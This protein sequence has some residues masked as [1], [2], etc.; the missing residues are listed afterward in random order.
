M[1]DMT[2]S[3]GGAGEVRKHT[4]WFIALGIVFII[5]GV[6]AI[7]MPLLA[8]IAVALAVG[9]ALILLGIVQLVQAWSMRSWGGVVWQIIIGLVFVIGGIGML[10]NPIVAAVT[11]TLLIGL[12]FIIKGVVQ[13]VLG[14]RYRPHTGWGWM[15]AAGI[16][17]IIV[18]LM[19]LA[20]WPF[21]AAWAPGTLAGISLVF[22]GWSY[23]A[24]ALAARRVLT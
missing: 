21:S 10:V 20:S 1:T 16:I 5:G 22:S 6:L 23:I 8:G 18:G 11:L 12:V 17:A 3:L 13:V 24:I 4:G 7:A 15:L 2:M 14:F 19:I 9:W